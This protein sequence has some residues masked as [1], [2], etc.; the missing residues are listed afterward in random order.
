LK[1]LAVLRRSF[2]TFTQITIFVVVQNPFL[3][4]EINLG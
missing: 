1:G 4:V 2:L 3:N